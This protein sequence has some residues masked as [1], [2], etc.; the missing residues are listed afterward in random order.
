MA[1]DSITPVPRARAALPRRP[2]ARAGRR[3]SALRHVCAAAVALALAAGA[4]PAFADATVF[5]GSSPASA[6]GSVLG[7]AL[8]ISR[9][10]IG[11]EFEYARAR[12]AGPGAGPRVHSGLLSLLVRTPRRIAR[13]RLYA[14]LGA[15]LYRESGGP[16][17]GTNL[18]SG[19]GG[20]I[21]VAILG[22]LGLRVDYRV[23]R[24]RGPAPG[25]PR[26]RLYAGAHLAF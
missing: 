1:S 12:P 5:V 20:G 11:F 4:R 10:A 21:D 18:A 22:P 23:L 16:R 26:Q 7:A 14:S 17:A 6:D 3:R 24:F 15:G 13:M 25:H 2:E 19:A 9:R 8:G